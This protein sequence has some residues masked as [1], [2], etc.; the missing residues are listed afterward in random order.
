MFALV[1][2][3]FVCLIIVG[4]SAVFLS[5]IEVNKGETISQ[6]KKDVELSIQKD[7]AIIQRFINSD[8]DLVVLKEIDN[9]PLSIEVYRRDS[10]IYWNEAAIATQSAA[11]DGLV[12]TI[13]GDTS[14]SGIIKLNFNAF[15]HSL[16][17]LGVR[18]TR[19]VGEYAFQVGK[20]KFGLE[21]T[22]HRGRGSAAA[23]EELEGTLRAGTSRTGSPGPWS[24]RAR[25]TAGRRA[26]TRPCASRP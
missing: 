23:P 16:S 13:V 11:E 22:N 18:L 20:H 15:N 8:D 9:S 3:V 24:W 17:S 7:T 26:L 14:E 1:R 25:D 2:W 19:S 10:I 6:V 12:L 5:Q 4:L 21:F